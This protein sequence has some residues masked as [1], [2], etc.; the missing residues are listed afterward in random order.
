[1][2]D[3]E[4]NDV[5][6]HWNNFIASAIAWTP[7]IITAL[8]SALLIY[9]IGSWI[10]RLLKRMIDRA[11]ERRKMDVSLQRFLSNLIGWILNI[12]LFIVVVTQL[13][14]QTSAFVAIIGAAGLAIGLALQG[15]LSNFAGGILILLLKPFRVGDYISSSANVSGTV[16]EIDI[17]NTKLNTPQNQQ[18]VV[19]NGMLSNSSIT[20]Y[21]V[22][23]TRR[24][25]FDI[26]VSYSADL[27]QAKQILLEV[28]QNN[29]YAFKDPAPQVVV[30]ELGDSAITLSVRATT[31]NENFWTMQ[32]QLIINCK[33]ALDQAGIEIPFPQR[34]I[35]IR[36][37]A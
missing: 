19:P 5:Q 9:L 32:E 16:I 4:L 34:D 20:N 37:N 11:F 12:L 25:W 36:S 29:E 22:L 7:R 10:I 31:S 21:T 17:F 24:T 2:N 35:H 1:M 14:V 28:V 3:L 27:K 26:G 13:G 6:A 33:E 15:S 23:G 30:N 18:L 8:I